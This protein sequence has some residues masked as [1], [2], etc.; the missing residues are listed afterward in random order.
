MNIALNRG[1]HDRR[2]LTV[3]ISAGNQRLQM[4]N[5]SLHGTGRCDELRQEID[6]LLEFVA[7]IVDRGDQL[8]ADDIVKKAEETAFAEVKRQT[9]QAAIIKADAENEAANII[10]KAKAEAEQA[11]SK[12][13]ISFNVFIIFYFYCYVINY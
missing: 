11:I 2:C 6:L 13:I 12:P 7:Y 10:E 8:S 3:F 4:L 1:D 9:D 5:G